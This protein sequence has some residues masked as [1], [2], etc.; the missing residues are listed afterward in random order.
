[1]KELLDRYFRTTLHVE[2][3]KFNLALQ[4]NT[5]IFKFS[6]EIHFCIKIFFLSG[7]LLMFG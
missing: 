3:V 7:W 4:V 2:S 1:M 5:L 6:F